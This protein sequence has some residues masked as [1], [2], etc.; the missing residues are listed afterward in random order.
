[1]G[2]FPC[3]GTNM[4]NVLNK[5]QWKKQINAHWLTAAIIRPMSTDRAVAS[6]NCVHN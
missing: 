4:V 5:W 1:M 3:F 6:S 2:V